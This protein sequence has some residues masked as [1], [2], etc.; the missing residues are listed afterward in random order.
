MKK[1]KIKIFLSGGGSGG[2]VTPLLAIFDELKKKFPEDYEFVWIGTKNG[3][4]KEMLV[5]EDILFIPI[6]S[7]KL[8]RYFAWQ[9]FL[10]IFFIFLAF[11]QSLFL[12]IKYKPKMILSAGGF[13]SVPL[14]WAGYFLKIPVMIH[15]MDARAGLAN[16]LMAPI[17]KVITT[18]FEKSKDDYG[19]KAIW[20][21][22]P[23]RNK[24]SDY[25]MTKKEAIQKLGLFE[26]LPIVLVVG[27][28]TGASSINE[29]I[30]KNIDKLTKH[31]QIVHITGKG[32]GDYMIEHSRYRQFEFLD[33]NGMLK[34]F[35]AST[36]VVSRCGIGILTELSYFSKASI[37]I[38]IINSQQEDNAKIFQDNNACVLLSES[39][40]KIDLL[41]KT[42]NDL[43]FDK[44]KQAELSKNISVIIKKEALEKMIELIKNV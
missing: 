29:I 40:L 10:D 22:N 37:L 5:G 34:V 25:K 39:D 6:F 38:P 19:E 30:F 41:T 1:N 24:L 36:L 18:T 27:G 4:E 32:K 2:P 16:K 42:I 26:T 43:L 8:R 11:W 14:A 44:E 33:T 9:N 31:C 13:V 20:I 15:Q 28:G 17:A 12:L 35:T 7:G 23:V 21:G 3:I